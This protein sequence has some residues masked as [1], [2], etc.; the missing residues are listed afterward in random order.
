MGS[1]KLIKRAIKKYSIENFTKEILFELNS[2]EELDLKEKELITTEF[3]LLD[4]TYNICEGGFGGGFRYF[5]SNNE[6][7]IQR[8]RKI[9]FSR[10]YNDPKFI[11]KMSEICK[12]KDFTYLKDLHKSGK[13]NNL[14]FGHNSEIDAKLQSDEIK[15]KRKDSFKRIGHQQREKNS[16]YG[17]PRSE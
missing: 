1:G 12:N 14:Y 13:F 10:D 17:K 11:K 4:N 16:N 2:K 8:N 7:V 15:Q 3:C 9:S 6:L 5:N